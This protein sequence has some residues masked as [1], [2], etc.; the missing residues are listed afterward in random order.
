M[1]NSTQ[2][3]ETS[4][5]RQFGLRSL[6]LLMLVAGPLLAWVYPRAERLLIEQLQPT[7]MTPAAPVPKRRPDDVQQSIMAPFP[8]SEYDFPAT[9]RDRNDAAMLAPGF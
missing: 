1:S 4:K 3:V 9:T 5:R 2:P 7:T 6:L 8:E